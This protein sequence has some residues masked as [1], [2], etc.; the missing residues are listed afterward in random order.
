MQ[1]VNNY[2]K[3]VFNGDS[4]YITGINTEDRT[5]TVSFDG[6]RKEYQEKELDDLMLSYA[7]TIHKSQGSEYPVVVMPVVNAHHIMLQRNLLYTGITRAKK[8]LILIGNQ[9]AI[10]TA[11]NTVHAGKRNTL[12]KELLEG[13][14]EER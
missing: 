9:K 2:D 6:E 14:V 8:M 11:A 7:I 1:T 5:I 12:L 4:G 10:E 13:T 3:N